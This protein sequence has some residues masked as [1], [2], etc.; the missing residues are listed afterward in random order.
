MSRGRDLVAYSTWTDGRR[1]VVVIGGEGGR[2]VRF[3]RGGIVEDLT[4]RYFLR[5]FRLVIG[6]KS[7]PVPSKEGER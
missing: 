3:R 6:G 4:E 5:R 7:T 2:T 1:N